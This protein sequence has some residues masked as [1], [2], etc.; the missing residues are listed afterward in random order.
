MRICHIE[1]KHFRGIQFANF[2]IDEPLVCLVGAGDSSKSTILD[3]I[4][5]TLSPNWF[6]P[7]D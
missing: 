7:I 5:Y 1:I 3:A 6:I 4:E 2:Q